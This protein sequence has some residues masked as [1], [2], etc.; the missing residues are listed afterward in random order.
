MAKKLTKRERE[1]VNKFIFANWKVLLV[2]VLLVIVLIGVAYY[3][4]WLDIL[5]VDK[6]NNV[7]P[8]YST[9]GGYTKEVTEFGNLQVNFL[10]VGQA[11]CIVIELPD[12]RTMMI[13]TGDSK[14]DRTVISEFFEG[15]NIK[16]IDYLLITHSDSDHVG[17]ADWLLET[18]D[19]GFIFRPYV[20]SNNSISAG[21]PDTFNKKNSN[22]KAYICE[23]D[24]YAN[25]IVFAYNEGCTV[26]YFNKDSDF[27]NTLK[28][29]ESS[30]TYTFD[31]LT[32][33]AS[34]KNISYTNAND[35]SPIMMLE[36]AGRKIIFNGDAEEENLGEYCD[37]YGDKND[38]DVLKVGHHGSRNATTE[39]YISAITPEYAVIQNGWNKNY[40]HPHKEALQI[41]SNHNVDIYRTD[42]NGN[43]TLTINPSGEM[44]WEFVEDD[45]SENLF[46][47]EKM[48]ELHVDNAKT[49]NSTKGKNDLEQLQDFLS[50]CI[51][52]NDR[53][54]VSLVA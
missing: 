5:F 48:I 16:Y 23:S 14:S 53:K 15:N 27:S 51:I 7:P 37:T 21:V 38:V 49:I 22:N 17:N 6:D 28:C 26:E 24:I 36:Y 39:E 43:I 30:M 54:R 42:T 34:V 11:D 13:D 20:Y 12:Q 8:N 32:P 45:M 29:G 44:S 33:T 50:L 9:A 1:K 19:V 18:Y 40:K 52:D 2:L 46:D 4:G 31:F 3:M 35:Y 25:F 10:Q 47:G 41:L